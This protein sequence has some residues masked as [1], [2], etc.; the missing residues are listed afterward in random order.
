VKESDRIEAVV[1]N[2]RAVGADAD[3]LPDGF[4]VRGSTGPLR[5]RVATHGDHRMAMAFG[6]LGAL[7]GNE[8]EIDDPA[9]VAVSY[10]AFWSHL[11]AVTG[12]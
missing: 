3:E 6:I 11:S 9:C 4:V 12:A 5:G 10:P 7:P 2:L 8:I 1:G